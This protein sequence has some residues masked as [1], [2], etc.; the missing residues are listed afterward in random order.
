M[1]Y[2]LMVMM[3]MMMAVMIIMTRLCM[4]RGIAEGLTPTVPQFRR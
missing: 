3:M 4:H 2:M 1:K